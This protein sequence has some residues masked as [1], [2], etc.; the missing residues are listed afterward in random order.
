M[1]QQSGDGFEGKR[2][3][4]EYKKQLEKDFLQ[5]LIIEKIR[6]AAAVILSKVA[7]QNEKARQCEGHKIHGYAVEHSGDMR[8]YNRNGAYPAD[9]VAP[10]LARLFDRCVARHVCPPLFSGQWSVF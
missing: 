5:H 4:T 10:F 3:Q 2:Q 8:R 7:R 1:K 6:Q 9:H